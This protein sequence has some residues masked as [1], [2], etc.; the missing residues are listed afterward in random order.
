M[1]AY[2]YIPQPPLADFVNL[3]WFYERP[4]LP[5]ARERLLPTGTVELVF[6]LRDD[7]LRVCDGQAPDRCQHFPGAL[8]CGPHAE[9][10]IID[11]DQ[12]ESTMGVH[13]KPGGAFPFFALPAS[14]LCNAHVGLDTLWG[15]AAAELRERLLAAPT[16]D[17]K[18]CILEQTLLAQLARPLAQ[19]SAVAFALQA[20]HAAPDTQTIAAITAQ[21][22]FSPRRFFDLFTAEVGLT[23]KRFCRIRRFQAALRRIHA[24]SSVDWSDLA[25][26]CGYFDQSHFIND[27]RAFSGLTPTAYLAQ[28][29]PQLNHV[30]LID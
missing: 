1:L 15:R 8:L 25:L 2:S 4:A 21:I 14:E 29:G 16:P 18:F 10:F 27:F 22:G 19:N 26:A 30:P 20:L 11:T 3:F 7:S 13:F 28:Q 9:S 6:N 17:A 23:P 12:Q 5:H 24:G